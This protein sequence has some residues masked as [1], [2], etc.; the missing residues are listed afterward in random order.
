MVEQLLTVRPDHDDRAQDR[1][2]RDGNCEV[3]AG[4]L[5]EEPSVQAI[6]LDGVLPLGP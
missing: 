1:E 4:F 5:A 3:D 6:D 2:R